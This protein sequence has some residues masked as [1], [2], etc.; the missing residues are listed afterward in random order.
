[1]V[2]CHPN[3]YL[4]NIYEGEKMVPYKFRRIVLTIISIL[5]L[6]YSGFKIGVWLKENSES[7]A[8]EQDYIDQAFILG[9]AYEEEQEGEKEETLKLDMEFLKSKNDTTR[10]WIKVGG[11]NIN[12]PVV[13]AGDN[14]FY[15]THNFYKQY[16][17]VGWVF[18]DYRNKFDGTDRNIIIYG[19]NRRDGTMFGTLKNILKEDWYNNNSTI[20]FFD[21]KGQRECKIFAVYRVPKEDY[22]I[23]TSFNDDE[24]YKEFINTLKGRSLKNFGVDVTTENK[25]LT[26]ST[27]AND[28]RYR[29]VLH[30]VFE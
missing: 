9:D 1:M 4:Y 29:V 18:A 10:G 3:F 7:K 22:Y 16:S 8:I 13:Q 5:L 20:T 6:A 28:N 17:G 12:Y 24:E 14:D 23:T 30:A 21:E 11:T 25:I 2:T 15:L 26:L 19:H 27:C